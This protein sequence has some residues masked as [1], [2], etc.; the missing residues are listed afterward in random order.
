[1]AE[2]FKASVLKTDIWFRAKS[3]VRILLPALLNQNKM[4]MEHY[5]ALEQ[6]EVY[7]T[8]I[9]NILA[10]ETSVGLLGVMTNFTD[11]L[12]VVFVLCTVFVV[13]LG[14][15]YYLYGYYGIGLYKLYEFIGTI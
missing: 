14:G 2:W 10:Y 8:L 12:L 13:W 9:L 4:V 5:Q 6:F 15:Y 7:P 11:T 1:M 3:W